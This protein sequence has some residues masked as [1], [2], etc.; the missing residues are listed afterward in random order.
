MTATSLLHF[1]VKLF[2]SG[3]YFQAHEVWEDLWRETVGPAKLYYQGLIH[4]AVGMYHLGRGNAVGARSQLSKAIL[5]LE[6]GTQT[7]SHFDTAQ[8]ISQLR[9]AMRDLSPAEVRIVA[10]K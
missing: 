7:E 9:S 6:Q 8:F 4:A 5:R 10:L 2:N 1:G 3:D